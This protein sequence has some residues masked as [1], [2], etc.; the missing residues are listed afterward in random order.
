MRVE[1][2]HMVVTEN[3]LACLAGGKA[4]VCEAGHDLHATAAVDVDLSER[5][6]P[7]YPLI[8]GRLGRAFRLTVYEAPSYQG[9]LGYCTGD[10]EFS[11]S[12]LVNNCWEGF[13]T[14]AVL[15]L[16][17]MP[18]AGCVLDFGSHVGWYSILAGLWGRTAL[19]V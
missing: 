8:P 11:R 2:W 4:N 9:T 3:P 16:F 10:D 14:R 1:V 6:V 5:T 15:E 19:A 18:G 12:I 17:A 7:D 13:E